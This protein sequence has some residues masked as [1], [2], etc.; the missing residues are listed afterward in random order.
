MAPFVILNLFRFII[1]NKKKRIECFKTINNESYFWCGC[2]LNFQTFQFN[3]IMSITKKIRILNNH[4]SL[5]NFLSS[6]HKSENWI[7]V[8]FLSFF[9]FLLLLIHLQSLEYSNYIINEISFTFNYSNA[10][11]ATTNSTLSVLNICCID[12]QKARIPLNSPDGTNWCVIRPGGCYL[13]CIMFWHRNNF[14][15]FIVSTF[16]YPSSSYLPYFLPQFH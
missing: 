5:H 9:H 13:I 14:N 10:H 16:K 1:D 15:K 7:N 12:L 6:N 11:H 4:K 8:N 3:K 2:E